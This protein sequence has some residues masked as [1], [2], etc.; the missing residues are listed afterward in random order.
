MQEEVKEREYGDRI[1]EVENASFTPLVFSTAVGLSKET[2]IAYKRMAVLLASKRKTE[3]STT[4]AWMRCSLSF[5]LISSAVASIR[6]TWV[7]LSRH[8]LETKLFSIWFF[9]ILN[10]YTYFSCIYILH[11]KSSFS[12][13]SDFSVLLDSNSVRFY[14]YMMH[15]KYVVLGID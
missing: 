13:S 3:Y 9:Y 14:N 15:C 7:S 12:F 6:G 4:L 2:S 5:A 8:A 10:D 11:H 1:R